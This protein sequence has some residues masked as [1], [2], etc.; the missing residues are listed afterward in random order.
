[1]AFNLDDYDPVEKRLG[2]KTDA[3][4]FWEDYPDGQI[5]TELIEHTSTRFIVKAFIYRTEVDPRPWTTG[6]AEETIQA[7]GVNATSALE[8]CE[9]SAIGRA[10]ANAGYASKGK[11]ASRTEMEKVVRSK[12]DSEQIKVFKPLPKPIDIPEGKPLPNE[13]ETVIWDEVEVKAVDEQVDFM[14]TLQESLNA[15]VIDMRCKHGAMISKRGQSKTGRAYYG[16]VCAASP[17][18]EQCE[19]VWGKEMSGKWVFEDK[20]VHYGN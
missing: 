16:Y 2:Y 18:S 15:E 12:T 11:R 5:H 1:M 14:Q 17:K 6:L 19:P 20:A 9:T 10:L 7:R 3:K 4:S 13:P 8:N